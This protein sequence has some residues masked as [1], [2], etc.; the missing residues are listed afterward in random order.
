MIFA[1]M[2]LSCVVFDGPSVTN[3]EDSG[4]KYSKDCTPV[5]AAN[6]ISSGVYRRTCSRKRSRIGK[7]PRCE[8]ADP[9][10]CCL[11][12]KQT[13]AATFR[14]DSLSLESPGE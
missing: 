9:R 5:R 3:Q 12:L 6:D 7:D 14:L 11:E 2:E 13:Y 1:D 8:P 4:Q 10:A